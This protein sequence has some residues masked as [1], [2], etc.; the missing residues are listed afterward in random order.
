MVDSKTKKN[1]NAETAE[2]NT[3]NAKE[4][5]GQSLTHSHEA[6]QDNKMM[7]SS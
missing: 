6:Y 2:E 1:N 5:S 7:S 4:I 3:K